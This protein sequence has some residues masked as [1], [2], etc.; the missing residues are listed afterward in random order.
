[1][2]TESV[3][4]KPLPAVFLAL[5]TRKVAWMLRTV[6]TPQGDWLVV[7]RLN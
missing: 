7:V 4:M 6:S 5:L 3:A 1:M 2:L